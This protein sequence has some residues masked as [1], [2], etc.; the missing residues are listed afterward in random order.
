MSYKIL[1]KLETAHSMECITDADHSIALDKTVL[2]GCVVAQR[3]NRNET[4][5][6]GCLVATLCTL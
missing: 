1:K 6:H 2:R 3:H 5:P 4:V